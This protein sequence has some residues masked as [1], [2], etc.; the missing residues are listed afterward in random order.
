MT[1]AFLVY[2]LLLIVLMCFWSEFLFGANKSK[3]NG[4]ITARGIVLVF[5]STVIFSVIL[6]LR[7]NVGGDYFAYVDYYNKTTSNV[8]YKDVPFEFGFYY[9]IVVLKEFGLPYWSLFLTMCAIQMIFLGSWL[10][11]Q[12]DAAPWLV[13]FYFT[14]LL[15]FESLNII[16]QAT[17]LM[18]VLFALSCLARGSVWRYCAWIALAATLH[19]SALM[20]L[21][22]ALLIGREWSKRRF[23]LFSLLVLSYLVSNEIKEILFD[24]L[25]LL[26]LLDSGYSSL[27]NELFFESDASVL[28]VGFALAFL[29]DA[30]VVYFYPVLLERY[31][32]NGFLLYFNLFYMGALLTPVVYFSNYIAFTRISFYLTSFRFVMLGFLLAY[33]MS[34][35]ARFGIAKLLAVALILAYLGMFFV[36]IVR[37]AAW[38]SPFQFVFE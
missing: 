1:Q 15:G 16:R 19:V 38:C 14:T 33:L 22:L 36:A 27:Q 6:G 3:V 28:S 32:S 12:L 21:P 30:L 23:I 35:N 8:S 20:M 17:S 37:G 11:R 25:P 4:S 7:Y 34:K 10:T 13:F 29:V 9:L 18:I 24:V 5:F 2:G 26:S 31:R